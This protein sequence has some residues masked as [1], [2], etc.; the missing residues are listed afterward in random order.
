MRDVICHHKTCD[1]EV[2]DLL[3]SSMSLVICSFVV[4]LS[5]WFSHDV[6]SER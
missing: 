4:E 1:E 5:I 6:S 3:V 2:F